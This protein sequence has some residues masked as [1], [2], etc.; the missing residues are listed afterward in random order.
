MKVLLLFL[1]KAEMCTGGSRRSQ[2]AVLSIGL[3][4][5]NSKVQDFLDA[6]LSNDSAFPSQT[7]PNNQDSS[8]LQ[9]SA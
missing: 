9:H 8:W 7:G 4:R 3:L 5:E 6:L 2:K 1:G